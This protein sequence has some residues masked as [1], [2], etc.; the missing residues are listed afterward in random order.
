M[1]ATELGRMGSTCTECISAYPG[2]HSDQCSRRTH[3]PGWGGGGVYVVC[4]YCRLHEQQT[5]HAHNPM[6]YAGP[7]KPIGL[8]GYRMKPKDGPCAKC[9]NDK[10][11][12][13][14]VDPWQS[15]TVITT[16]HPEKGTPQ[17]LLWIGSRVKA[18]QE[19]A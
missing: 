7:R 6:G 19:A 18:K 9:G 12:G 8:P 11:Q 17:R 3:K 4:E 1:N 10:P 2:E 16:L 13:S 15:I 14:F 5:I